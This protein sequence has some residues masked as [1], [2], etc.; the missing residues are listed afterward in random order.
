[1]KATSDAQISFLIAHEI[2]HV[3]LGHPGIKAA[4]QVESTTCGKLTYFEFEHMYEY[5]ADAFAL[6]WLRSKVINSFRYHLH[7]TRTCGPKK[8]AGAAE[9]LTEALSDYAHFYTSVELLFIIIHFLEAFYHRL[10]Q[11]VPE[12]PVRALMTSHPAALE[13]WRRLQQHCVYDI[14]LGSGFNEYA[15]ELLSNVLEYITTVSSESIGALIK[16]A[17]A[18]ESEN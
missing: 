11:L 9:K 8:L 17:L 14:P 13:R 15:T 3:A 6:D 1:V 10:T 7:P 18:D 12:L 5:E 2:G 16:E 4:F